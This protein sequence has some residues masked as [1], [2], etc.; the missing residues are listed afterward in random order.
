MSI[1]PHRPEH[2][3][4]PSPHVSETEARVRA[5]ETILIEK[6]YVDPA[7]LDLL[8]ETYEERIGPRNG[9]RVVA[10]AWTDPEYRSRLL[11]NATEAIASVP[12]VRRRS[13]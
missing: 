2:A 6:G 7:A 12:R 1:Q 11:A 5:L 13:L 3:N 9:A 4:A 8:V 10:K